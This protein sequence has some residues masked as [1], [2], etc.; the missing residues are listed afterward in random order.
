MPTSQDIE[1]ARIWL[2]ENCHGTHVRHVLERALEYAAAVQRAGLCTDAT[3]GEDLYRFLSD[4]RTAAARRD[5]FVE[6][7]L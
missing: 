7:T 6:P 4:P 5:S 2:T 3:E 1:M